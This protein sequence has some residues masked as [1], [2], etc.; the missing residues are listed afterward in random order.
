MNP[1]M[2]FRASHFITPPLNNLTEREVTVLLPHKDWQ[3]IE[4]SLLVKKNVSQPSASFTI[5]SRDGGSLGVVGPCCG[6]LTDNNQA[7]LSDCTQNC[8]SR[9][10]SMIIQSSWKDIK[11][12]WLF[13]ISCTSRSSIRSVF[14]V[15]AKRYL[16]NHKA[17]DNNNKGIYCET[18]RRLR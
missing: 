16:L 18:L 14:S 10:R 3:N 4:P 13:V 9:C 8:V 17:K 12:Q 1:F 5:M 11:V 6:E 15:V 2:S 7:M